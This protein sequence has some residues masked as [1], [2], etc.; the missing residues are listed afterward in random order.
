ME[1][2]SISKLLKEHNVKYFRRSYKAT[3]CS[4]SI[5]GK[6]AK[7]PFSNIIKLW[8]RCNGEVVFDAEWLK[9]RGL[10]KLEYHPSYPNDAL[11]QGVKK[12][13]YPSGNVIAGG[14]GTYVVRHG[15]TDAKL[16]VYVCENGILYRED[17]YYTVKYSMNGTRL[18]P[19]RRGLLEAKLRETSSSFTV[20]DFNSWVQSAIRASKI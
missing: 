12:G 4:L 9:V 3:I 13:N 16:Y 5:N 20:K 2:V 19:K 11:V 15:F 18:T 10:V 6:Y 7:A 8:D 17:I 14:N 1:V